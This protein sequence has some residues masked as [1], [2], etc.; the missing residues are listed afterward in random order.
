[1]LR[2]ALA[3]ILRRNRGGSGA[4]RGQAR[5]SKLQTFHRRRLVLG[6][7]R[8]RVA[9]LALA[10]LACSGEAPRSA[11]N[12]GGPLVL[13]EESRYRILA[14]AVSP[15]SAH[16]P[17]ELRV[18]VVASGG[19]HVEPAAPTRLSLESDAVRI[20]P[21]A[22]TNEDATVLD[23]DGFEFAAALHAEDPGPFQATGQLKFGIC[24]APDANCV[25]VRRDLEI[26]LEIVFSD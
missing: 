21:A 9:A 26:P 3:C 14:S 5:S 16:A 15:T 10:L 1:M 19:W 11:P 17:G 13:A 24:E 20:E 4:R 2:L 7:V 25:I 12:D 18:S 22:F 23:G 6:S 8:A